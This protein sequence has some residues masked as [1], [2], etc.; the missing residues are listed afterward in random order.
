MVPVRRW[1]LIAGP[2]SRCSL[3]GAGRTRRDRAGL[4]A[5]QG[6]ALV[7]DLCGVRE[8]GSCPRY[9]E[10]LEMILSLATEW[11]NKN[12]RVVPRANTGILETQPR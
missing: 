2:S 7:D 10:D 3:P 12:N 11:R 5:P 1:T 9:R 6:Q 8:I 4:L